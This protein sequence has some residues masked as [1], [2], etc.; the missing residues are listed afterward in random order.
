MN[1]QVKSLYGFNPQSD[2]RTRIAAALGQ[3]MTARPTRGGLH[4]RFFH[5]ALGVWRWERV[6]YEGNVR[7]CERGFGTYAQCLAD[8]VWRTFGEDSSD[9][10]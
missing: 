7:E 3:L 1:A 8:A 5:D 6:D 4:W 9:P 10:L 2:S